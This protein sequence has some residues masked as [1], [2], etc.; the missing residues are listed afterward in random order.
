MNPESKINNF[1]LKVNNFLKFN[2]QKLQNIFKKTLSSTREK[3]IY[4]DENFSQ[5][6]TNDEESNYFLEKSNI[7]KNLNLKMNIPVTTLEIVIEKKKKKF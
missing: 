3:D 7:L 4:L 5:K 6:K 2:Q 1:E